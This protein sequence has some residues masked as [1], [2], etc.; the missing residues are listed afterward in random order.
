MAILRVALCFLFSSLLCLDYFE[1][2]R[3][4]AYLCCVRS[5]LSA[6]IRDERTE[7]K[8]WTRFLVVK[9]RP[10]T[11]Q[12]EQLYYAPG[13]MSGYYKDLRESDIRWGIGVL[14][15]EAPA[16]FGAVG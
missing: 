7:P 8:P 14:C 2:D 1:E 12:N 10:T 5:F 11:L 4:L 15:N 9:S 13:L 3:T 6:V 16:P